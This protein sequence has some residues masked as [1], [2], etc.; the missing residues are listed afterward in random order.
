MLKEQVLDQPH[1]KLLS[2]DLAQVCV[3]GPWT[4]LV[5]NIYS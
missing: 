5:D 1:I 2:V 3:S 4:W